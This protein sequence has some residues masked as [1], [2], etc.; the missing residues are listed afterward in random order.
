MRTFPVS[1]MKKEMKTL[2]K[3]VKAM[4]SKTTIQ[5][6][7]L[8]PLENSVLMYSVYNADTLEKNH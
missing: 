5:H 8:M 2:H 3:A 4:Y 1:Y 7:K 6:N